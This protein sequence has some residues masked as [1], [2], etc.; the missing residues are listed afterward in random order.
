LVSN[1][2]YAYSAGWYWSPDEENWMK[3]STIVVSGGRYDEDEPTKDN[4]ELIQKLD[5]KSYAQGLEILIDTVVRESE[6]GGFGKFN[7]KLY[8]DNAEM[9]SKKE[10]TF[11]YRKTELPTT[12]FYFRFQNNKWEW[13]PDKVDWI[14]VPRIIA[15]G[16]FHGEP[17]KLIESLEG[18]DFYEGAQI[19]FSLETGEEEVEEKEEEEYISL[20][21]TVVVHYSASRGNDNDLPAAELIKEALEEKGYDVTLVITDEPTGSRYRRNGKDVQGYE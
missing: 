13:S 5:G 12:L 7:G 20:G 18:K 2:H 21:E 3:V 6:E 4:G 19:L 16:N 17:I 9:N 14:T 1:L 10:F 15:S 11:R 8:A